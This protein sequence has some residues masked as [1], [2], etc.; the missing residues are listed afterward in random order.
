[1]TEDHRLGTIC[2]LIFDDLKSPSLRHVRDPHS[3]AK[4]A[5]ETGR[6]GAGA[7]P[8]DSEPLRNWRACSRD[9]SCD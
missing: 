6:A 9:D 4:L 5:K 3:V 2:S 1:M 7:M 8:S